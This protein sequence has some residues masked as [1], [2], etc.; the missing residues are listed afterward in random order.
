[1]VLV[2]ERFVNLATVTF[3]GKGASSSPMV[4][5]PPTEVTEFGDTESSRGV[6]RNAIDDV[7]A[8]VA[9]PRPLEA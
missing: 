4:V 7:V 9:A 2:T 3:K 6:I 5:L 1:M 8:K